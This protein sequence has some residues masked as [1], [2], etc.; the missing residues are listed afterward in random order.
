[1][2]KKMKLGALLAVVAVAPAIVAPQLVAS[3]NA[4][5]ATAEYPDV[6]AGHWAYD[7]INTLSRAGIIEGRPGGNYYGNQAMTRY[8]FAVAIARLLKNIGPGQAGPVGPQGPAG[9]AGPAGSGLT[10][11]SRTELND[12]I[13]ALRT[14][15]ARE[16]ADLG[17]RVDALEGRVTNLENRV[18]APPRLTISPGFLHRSGSATYIDN[19]T[20][21]SMLAGVGAN[22]TPNGGPAVL[23]G[24]TQGGD[25]A[26][27]DGYVRGKFSYTDFELRLTDRVTDRLSVNAAL[28]SLS[29]NQEDAWSNDTNGSINVREA[30][31]V[32]NLGDRSFLGARGL[33]LILGRQRTKIGQ[34]LLYDN[35]LAPTD[36]IH[37]QFNFGPLQFNAFIGDT[38]NNTGLQTVN[39]VN[40]S[41]DPYFGQ[42]AA[43]AI[44]INGAGGQPGG[45][46]V[47]FA[48][49]GGNN[50]A[51]DNESL[52]R[53]SF[54]LFK[55]AGNPVNIG[56]ARQ[57]DGVRSQR[58]DSLDLSVP[59]FN[60]TIGVE[61]VR[62]R[63]YADG[64]QA[65][66]ANAYNIT[67]PV[68][69]ARV[70]DLNFA[71]G[72]AND[73][74]EYFLSSAANPFARSY[75][76]ALFDRPLALGSPMINNSA[77][78]G[79]RYMAAK[80]TLDFNGT[81]RILRRLPLDFRYYTAEGTGGRDLGEV[82]TVG[83]TFNVS[84]GLDLEV[85]YGQYNPENYQKIRYFRVG[86]N[87]GF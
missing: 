9:P 28:R 54:N 32:A 63:Q 71:Y 33:N 23:P 41:R 44:G 24:Q 49:V 42:G 56:I 7:A 26:D 66:D 10:G 6:P 45:S 8:E 70:L 74:F 16:L 75:G 67:V 46:F 22:A 85:K 62:Q 30:F 13:N 47:G 68:L 55:I 86:A 59:L 48:G 18:A 77:G 79:T 40:N 82:M 50:F 31:A 53:A 39:G 19:R 29:S 4:Q 65:N 52:V 25:L 34:G 57:F 27:N 14:E 72:K 3:V 51:S 78:G 37:S 36:Q 21:G 17:V 64:T 61:Y 87:V 60:R 83:S 35:D 43:A 12:A 73:N 15:F 20:G 5:Q 81:L 84:P 38:N 1:M 80:K 11:V 76:E 69:R 58:G 2:N